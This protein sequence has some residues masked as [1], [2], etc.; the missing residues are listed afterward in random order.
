MLFTDTDLFGPIA[1]QIDIFEAI[2]EAEFAAVM[3]VKVDRYGVEA[4][5]IDLFG[6]GQ[7]SITGV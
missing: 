3:T 7:L 6:A 1:H 2:A 4:G 5:V